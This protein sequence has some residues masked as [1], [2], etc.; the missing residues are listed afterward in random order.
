TKPLPAETLTEF[1]TTL[2]HQTEAEI[3]KKERP[4]ENNVE[5]LLEHLLWDFPRESRNINPF[6]LPVLKRRMSGLPLP[7]RN[8]LARVLARE[9][10]P[11]R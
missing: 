4:L 7:E 6:S 2:K 9:A 10:L 11:I 3:K 8:I 1:V 5:A